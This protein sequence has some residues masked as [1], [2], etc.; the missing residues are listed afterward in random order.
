LVTP[1]FHPNETECGYNVIDTAL[2][3]IQTGGPF[4]H[5]L[6][7]SVMHPILRKWSPMTVSDTLRSIRSNPAC[8]I[9][10]SSPTHL[11]E[12]LPLAKL[13]EDEEPV[14]PL[15][16]NPDVTSTSV[17]TRDV[18]EAA[19]KIFARRERGISAIRISLSGLERRYRITRSPKLCR[20]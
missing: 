17:S 15:F 6:H 2:T 4:K 9:R 1:G 18:G 7:S 19:A 8:R 3:N 12:T 5:M 14:H 10:L 16:W 20:K 11:T 13:L